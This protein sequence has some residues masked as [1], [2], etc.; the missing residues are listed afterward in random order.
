MIEIEN[1]ETSDNNWIVE[2]E[3]NNW[4]LSY[5]SPWIPVLTGSVGSSSYIKE[6]CLIAKK[7]IQEVGL[8]VY[9]SE[10]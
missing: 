2:A 8:V 1:G 4:I 6:Q 7:N 3:W 5:A 10:R 9:F